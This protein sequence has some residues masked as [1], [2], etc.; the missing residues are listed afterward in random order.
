M[1][2][3]VR[4]DYSPFQLPLL[5]LFFLVAAS[6]LC[7]YLLSTPYYLL[8][9][10]PGITVL[11]LLFLG[12]KLNVAYYIFVFLIPFEFVTN[13]FTEGYTQFTVSKFLGL[14][15]TVALAAMFLVNKRLSSSLRSDFWPLLAFFAIFSLLSTLFSSHHATAVGDMRRMAVAFTIFAITLVLVTRKGFSRALPGVI[16]WSVFLN[17]FLFFLEYIL[18]LTLIP[19]GEPIFPKSADPTYAVPGGYSAFFVLTLPFIVH[20]AFFS[21]TAPRKV[22]YSLMFVSNIMALIYLGSRAAAVMLVVMTLFLFMEYVRMLKPKHVGFLLSLGGIALVAILLYVPASYWEAQKSVLE[23]RLDLSVA[24]RITYIEVAFDSFTK[25]P[26]LGTGPG[27]F[28]Y[29]YAASPHAARF[30]AEET[31]YRRHAHNTYLDVLAGHGLL[32]LGVFAAIAAMALRNFLK[33][34]SRYLAAGDR[35]KEVL[36]TSYLAMMIGILVLFLFLTDPWMKYFWIMVAASQIA[37]NIAREDHP[38]PE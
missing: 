12:H 38:E 24:R 27:T 26:L 19:G 20:R 13:L 3:K 18:G 22:L 2:E 17:F 14:W 15:I 31:D 7:I 33:A 23:P 32:G 11:A 36:V 1:S 4:A 21:P 6:V 9:L 8:S 29:T 34:R 35:G 10:L 37:L 5:T 25:R 16:V 28:F 30:A